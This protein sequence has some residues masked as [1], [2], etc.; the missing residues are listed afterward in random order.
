M[1]KA[2]RAIHPAPPML[3]HILPL[4]GF[5]F[6][7]AMTPGPNNLLLAA[8]GI[9]FG[10]RAT[11][12]QMVGVHMG[13]SALLIVVGLG[14]GAMFETYPVLQDVLRIAGTIYVLYLAWR[15][16]RGWA[17]PAQNDSGAPD[18]TG[19]DR[20]I[21]FTEAFLFQFINPKGVIMAI[22]VFAAYAIPGAGVW[23][24]IA[25]IVGV[26]AVVNV[27]SVTTWAGFGAAVQG[28]AGHEPA[29]SIIRWTLALMTVASVATL[30]L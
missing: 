15:I 10:F 9:R 27:L 22:T 8:S 21:R 1:D 28:I 17:V 5:T 11:I 13:Y 19:K 16:F 30:Y 25:L 23:T 12:P 4:F 6:A 3:Q 29:A 24:N 7:A 20:P 14:L 18:R 2:A 26:A